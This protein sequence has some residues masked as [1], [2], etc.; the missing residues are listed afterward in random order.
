MV[1]A[2]EKESLSIKKKRLRP[3]ACSQRW[4]TKIELAE[5][6][7]ARG[8]E[9]LTKCCTNVCRI[10][11]VAFHL[12]SRVRRL[13][14]FERTKAS[15]QN[16]VLES[17]MQHLPLHLQ[18]DQWRCEY[19]RPLHKCTMHCL[20]KGAMMQTT[21]TNKGMTMAMGPKRRFRGAC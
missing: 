20:A 5:E 8:K 14:C 12:L 3:K 19:G 2:Q 13:I 16:A 11:T 1:E 7:A 10:Q 18:A 9:E 15:N 6:W 17:H 4:N 21:T